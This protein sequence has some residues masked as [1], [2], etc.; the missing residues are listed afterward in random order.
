M[1]VLFIVLQQDFIHPEVRAILSCVCSEFRTAVAETRLDHEKITFDG[2]IVKGASLTLTEARKLKLTDDDLDALPFKTCRVWYGQTA[3]YFSKKDVIALR[4]AKYGKFHV[5]SESKAQ[6]RRLEK[7]QEL[8]IDP[9]KVYAR[10]YVKNGNGGV[11]RLRQRIDDY[12]KHDLPENSWEKV[13]SGKI[14][15]DQAMRKKEMQEALARRGLVLRNDSYLCSRYI[16]DAIG[17][18]QEIVKEMMVMDILRRRITSKLSDRCRS[19]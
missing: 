8:N 3:T 5:K 18:V 10:E 15:L 16:K 14:T 9:T 12:S 7:L 6:K 13:F 19:I 2:P 1:E 17:D 11:R 4:L